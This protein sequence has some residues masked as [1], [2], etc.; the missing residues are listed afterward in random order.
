MKEIYFNNREGQTVLSAGERRGLIFGHV[1]SISELNELEQMNI[2]KGLLWLEGVNE[3]ILCQSFFRKLHKKLFG[4][5]WKWAGKYRKSEKNIGI[6]PWKIPTELNKL[7]Q[8]T[9]YWIEN[10]TYEWPELI[11]RFHHRLVYIHPFP[12]GNGR[13]SRIVTNYLC[14][15]NNQPMPHWHAHLPP[16]QK[17]KLYIDALRKADMKNFEALIRY[18]KG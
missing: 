3:P 18:F 7:C 17:R 11:A 5:V 6:E 15:H 4:E 2:N 10:N 12:N 13:F 14:L 1:S 9:G 16:A 8:D